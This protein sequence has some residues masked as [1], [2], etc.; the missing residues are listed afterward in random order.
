MRRLPDRAHHFLA[1]SSPCY[2]EP[3]HTSSTPPG[4]WVPPLTHK[5]T[6]ACKTKHFLGKMMNWVRPFRMFLLW[7]REFSKHKNTQCKMCRVGQ[8][9]LL[10]VYIR[11]LWQGNHQTYGHVRWIYTLFIYLFIYMYI[12]VYTFIYTVLVDPG[13]VA[14]WLESHGRKLALVQVLVHAA[15]C[16]WTK[17]TEVTEA[18]G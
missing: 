16:L 8:N 11:Y 17:A 6:F 15:V 12:C 2:C 18:A 4:Q 9:H 3:T 13:G 7:L 1:N 14:T 5:H 10:M